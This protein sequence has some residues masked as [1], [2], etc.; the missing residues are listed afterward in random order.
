MPDIPKEMRAQVVSK[1][2]SMPCLK[3]VPVPTDIK[4]DEVLVKLSFSGIC[5]TDLHTVKHDWPITP[6]SPIIPG[7]EGVGQVV[8]T[9]SAVSTV[10]IGDWVGIKWINSTCLEC[11]FCT[12]G[13]DQLCQR[14]KMSGFSVDGTFAE[15]A[16]GQATSVVPI[17][18]KVTKPKVKPEL[19]PVLCA[20]VTVYRGLK[21]S[22]VKAGQSVAIVGAGGGL[23]SLAI[24][25][26]IAMGVR[27]IGID[28]GDEKEKLCREM[29]AEAFVDFKKMSGDDGDGMAEAV[30]KAV[31]GDG[32]GPHAVL[33]LSAAEKPFEQAMEVRRSIIISHSFS[34]H[35]HPD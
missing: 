5:H 35:P 29:G 28:S 6:K 27:P 20:G 2:G 34:N 8:K 1:P 14:A 12:T 13:Q 15:Y 9:G 24:Q 21:E 19:A 4:P 10:K 17:P 31:G 16:V 23:G 11:S 22:G 7:H 25:Y 3:T 26:A 32:L 18:E 33:V 30:K